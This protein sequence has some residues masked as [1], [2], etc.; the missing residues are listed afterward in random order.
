MKKALMVA[1]VASVIDQFNDR[2]LKILQDMGYEVHVAANFE[3][4]NTTSQ[5]R[6]YEYE[7]SLRDRGII[8]HNI[9][10]PR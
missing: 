5:E 9:T 2:N 10:F 8:V 7:R 1:T 3:S 6:V 4:G